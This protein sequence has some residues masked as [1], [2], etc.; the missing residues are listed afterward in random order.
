MA[1]F[2]FAKAMLADQPIDV[3]NNGN[4]K[5]DFTYV[6]DIVE[7]VVRLIDVIPGT[8]PV[9]GDSL[10][11]V[12][13]FRIVNIGKG[14]PVPLM[15]Y[16]GALEAALGMTAKKNFLPMQVGDVLATEACPA[17]LRQLIGYV[18]ETP[19]CVGLKAF[20]DWYRE[21]FAVEP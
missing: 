18:P 4:M 10:S 8:K 7:S 15:D 19:L 3:Y 21:Y 17:L 1:L 12:A 16:I 2:K 20:V 14:E 5:R 9:P 6:D 11:P 13:P